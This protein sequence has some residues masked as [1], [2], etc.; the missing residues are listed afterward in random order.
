MVS[1][2]AEESHRLLALQREIEEETDHKHPLLGL[3][4]NDTL[5]QL[6]LV[7]LSKRA[8]KLRSEFKVPDKRWWWIKLKVLAET[9][10]WDGLDVFA[11]SRRSPIGYEPFVQHLV[12]IGERSR[13]TAFVPRCDAK[14][15]VDLYIRCGDWGK[16]AQECKDRND[17]ARLQELRSMAPTS[18][19]QRE[20]DEVISRVK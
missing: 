8:E 20:V 5:S 9:K 10:D 11:K 2:M 6:L 17:K 15:R 3:S 7:G 13:A 18:L 12:H 19:A 16:A 14:M 1:Q 4:V